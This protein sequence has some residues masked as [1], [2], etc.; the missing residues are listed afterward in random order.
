MSYMTRC[1]PGKYCQGTKRQNQ[2]D[3]GISTFSQ[4]ENLKDAT[5]C[6][7]CTSGSFC[8]NNGLTAVQGEC[9]SGYFCFIGASKANPSMDTSNKNYGPCPNFLY[10]DASGGTGVGRGSVCYPGT[11][12][13]S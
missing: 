9:N 3:C 10:C 5:E 4:L 2:Q 8:T 11:Y 6:Q 7:K 1:A 13:N 12:K